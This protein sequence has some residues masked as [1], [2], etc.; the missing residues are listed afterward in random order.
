[1]NI[2]EDTRFRKPYY[3]AA[4]GL[5]VRKVSNGYSIKI[6]QSVNRADIGR[7]IIAAGKDEVLEILRE[8]FDINDGASGD[9]GFYGRE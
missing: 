1:M 2:M 5:S 8:I 9:E 6:N 3:Q 7:I 4:L